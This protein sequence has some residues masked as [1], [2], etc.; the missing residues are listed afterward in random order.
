ML[1]STFMDLVIGADIHF[2][3]VPMPAPTPTPI[4]HPFMGMVGDLK[5]LAVNLLISN[6]VD[7]A[8]AGAISAP[9]GPVVI[10]LMPATNTG[11]DVKNKTVLPHF[12]IPPGTMWTPMPKAPKP[13]IGLHA[14]PDPTR[15]SRR[16]ATRS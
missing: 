16:P 8:M 6:I 12:V 9:K 10:N 13:K 15:P 11:T 1:A 4:P 5:A 2:E 3:M 14:T 7:M